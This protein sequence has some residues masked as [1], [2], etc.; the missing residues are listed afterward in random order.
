MQLK[1]SGPILDC[2]GY[3]SAAR[4]YL[5][6]CEAAGIEVQARDRSRSIQLKNRGMDQPTLDLYERLS[7][8]RVADDAPFVQH[9]VPD[10]FW[11]NRGTSLSVGYTIFE[12]TRVPEAW[13]KPC[14][15]MDVVWTGSEYSRDAFVASGV[16]KPVRVLPH[17]IDT[18]LFSPGGPSWEISNR[19]AFAFLSVFD[20][21]ERKGWRE[22]LRAY[23]RAF[24]P[25][26][27]VCLI[28]KVFFGGFG[29]SERRDILRRI[30]NFKADEGVGE[31]APVLVY[32]HD[33]PQSDMPG[34]F[35]AADCYVGVSREGFGLP[36]CEAMACGLPAIGPS[37]GGNRQYMTEENSFLVE[38]IGT[39]PVS[40]EVVRMFPD[41]EGLEWAKYSEDH[42][43]ELMRQAFE[44]GETRKRKAAAGER[45]VRDGNSFEAIGKVMRSLLS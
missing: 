13:V 45:S 31:S 37:V 10:C 11:P 20:F 3:A 12:M 15:M 24:P 35:R 4:G 5:R 28:L 42:L 17:A 25:G 36:F 44:D 16:R 39:E 19:R 6:A 33:V 26:E 40:P 9:Q 1:W 22:L 18:G 27:D 38:Y 41:F 32:T 30:L 29:D 34:L 8:T 43:A 2:S 23:W 14:D 21:T 7:R